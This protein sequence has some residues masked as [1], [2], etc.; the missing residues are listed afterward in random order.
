[1]GVKSEHRYQAFARRQA[2]SQQ[3]D[4]VFEIMN[5]L[6]AVPKHPNAIRPWGS[7]HFSIGH[8]GYWASCPVTGFGYWYPTLRD[9]V[10]HYLVS[11]VEYDGKRWLGV[12]E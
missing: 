1:M 3:P 6:N 10:S 9:A 11:I 4:Y 5:N 12:L 8:G 2:D 7:L